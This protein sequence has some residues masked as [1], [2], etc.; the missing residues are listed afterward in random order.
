MANFRAFSRFAR[1]TALL[2]LLSAGAAWADP[3]LMISI[4]GLKPEYITHADEHGLRIPN[5]RRFVQEGTYADGVIPVLPS[6]TYPDHTTLITGVWPAEHGIINN[7]LFDPNHNLGG[8]WYWYAESIKVPTLWDAAHHAGIATASVSW[9]VSVNA[10]SVDT[11][12]P[13][14]WRTNS[15]AIG[16]NDQD[17][18]LMNAVSR[19]DDM[20]REMESRLGPYMPGNDTTVE[21]G[22]TIRTRFALDILEHKRPGFMT[23]HLSAMDESEHLHG[24]FSPEANQTLEAV[25][26]MVGQLMQ[27]ALADDPKTKVVIVSDHGFVAITHTVNLSIPFLEAGL[28]QLPTKRTGIE[29]MLSASN[30]EPWKVEFYSGGGVTAIMLHD[31]ADTVTKEKVHT[32]L[33]KLSADPNNGIDSI[34]D[35]KQIAARGGFPGASY[36]VVM[37]SGY[38]AGAATSGPLVTSGSVLKGSH[39][40]WPLFPEM[41]SSFFVLG[42]GVA[43]NRDLGVIDMRQ[44]APTVADILGVS[45]PAA[46]QPRLQIEQ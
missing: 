7:P 24:P 45:L 41:R 10:T 16:G 12:I 20:L 26:G 25:D 14:F 37:K 19:P 23:I 42:H 46:K 9:P 32:L 34:L 31:P 13:E 21:N 39:G 18:Y 44:I 4:D 38:T 22:D 3:V 27:A 33:V 29:A 2:F 28:M 40:F 30:P 36:L 15:P 11:L 43:H 5:L 6:V 17:R 8:A 35:E 1:I